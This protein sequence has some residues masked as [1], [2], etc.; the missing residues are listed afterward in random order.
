[1]ERSTRIAGA[2][3]P[4]AVLSVLTACSSS[5]SSTPPSS[6]PATTPSPTAASTAES[7]ALPPSSA[8]SAPST[9]SN[10]AL[11]AISV[12]P[13]DLP[14]GWTTGPVDVD[15]SEDA[16]HAA[17]VGCVGGRNTT[18]DRLAEVH[19]PDYSQGDATISSQVSAFKSASDVAVDVQL[20]SSPKINACY[21]A[22]AKAQLG[23]TVPAGTKINSIKVTVTPGAG[24][25]P[26]NL[27]GTATAQI[28]L[29]ING[30]TGDA[31]LNV[32]YITGPSIEAQVEFQNVGTPI[33]TALRNSVIA[34][35]AARAARG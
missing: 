16:S 30:Q 26:S 14:A 5:K 19:S 25:G 3:V 28:N 8:S 22:L 10:A 27:A 35:V 12:Q 31:F 32:A 9:P 21:A 6:S 20:L 34:K 23:T 2:L 24:G 15:R 13:S 7:S 4:A 29:T 18:P 11:N 33:P 1:M 17:L